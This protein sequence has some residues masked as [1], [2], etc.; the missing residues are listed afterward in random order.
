MEN[1]RVLA[2]AAGRPITESDVEMLLETL[3]PH[4]AM[5]FDSEEGRAQLVEELI[6]QELLFADAKE[7]ALDKEFEFLAEVERLKAS[8]LK[9][10]ALSKLFKA[11]HIGDAELKMFYN[12]NRAYMHKP[13]SVRASHILVNDLETAEKVLTELKD[14]LSFED[15]AAQYS[16]CPSKDQGGDLG[17][18]TRGKM[19]PEFEEVAFTLEPEVISN[20]VETQFGF[21]LIKV[22]EKQPAGELSFD[23]VK[24]QLTQ[25]LIQMKQH[26]AYQKKVNELAARYEVK[27]SL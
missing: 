17:S 7:R 9:Q 25:Q 4:T 14:G 11:I 6:N 1:N 24:D 10:Y 18:F 27:R 13:E 16:Q 23:D 8:Y 19:V 12:Q 21:H 22:T 3:D 26:E 20:P 5:Q 15:A 2:V